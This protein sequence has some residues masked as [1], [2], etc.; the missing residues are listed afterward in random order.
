MKGSKA[1]TQDKWRR[2]VREYGQSGLTAREF[3]QKHGHPLYQ[4]RYWKQK[5]GQKQAEVRFVPAVIKGHAE[6]NGGNQDGGLTL[7]VGKARIRLHAGFD[8]ALLREAIRA[9]GAEE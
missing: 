9:L 1:G 4:F 2:I 7:E 3:C 5:L 8:R 6:S